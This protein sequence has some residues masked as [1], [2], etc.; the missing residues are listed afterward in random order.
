MSMYVKN[1]LPQA[2]CD[3]TC[4]ICRDEMTLNQGNKKLACSHVFHATCLRSWLEHQQNCPTCRATVQLGNARAAGG[5]AAAAAAEPP[6]AAGA[7]PVRPPAAEVGAGGAAPRRPPPPGGEH[8]LDRAFRMVMLRNRHRAGGA[9]PEEGGGAEGGGGRR[10][11]RRILRARRHL[12]AAEG[13][14]ASTPTTAAAGASAT[15]AARVMMGGG[16][17]PLGHPLLPLSA[18]AGPAGTPNASPPDPVSPRQL[19]LQAAASAVLAACASY[20]ITEPA[21]GAASTSTGPAASPLVA[22]TRA[23]AA[24]INV[25]YEDLA[26]AVLGQSHA[27]LRA[28]E[29]SLAGPGPAATAATA[30]AAAPGVS[31]PSTAPVPAPAAIVPPYGSPSGAAESMGSG[32]AG[33]S[34]AAFGPAAAAAAAAETASTPLAPC[35]VSPPPALLEPEGSDGGSNSGVFAPV[36]AAA[37]VL[38]SEAE[39]DGSSGGSTYSS[40]PFGAHSF[41]FAPNP[42]PPRPRMDVAPTASEVSMGGPGQ[43]RAPAGRRESDSDSEEV[44]SPYRPPVQ[45]AAAEAQEAQEED[46]D[47]KEALRRRRLMRFGQ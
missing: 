38:S 22:A 21:G 18:L 41:S 40:N 12:G 34:S 31:G 17:L 19:R 39:A 11:D 8:P 42:V 33:M 23:V 35:P 43:Q 29:A 30:S 2:R 44:T 1:V 5:G 28:L 26:R 4:I 27:Q 47:E 6:G 37:D 10:G 45:G 7:A 36:A 3:H 15:D 24:L 16:G 13:G 46:V 32:A 25:D 20:P 14:P 9:G